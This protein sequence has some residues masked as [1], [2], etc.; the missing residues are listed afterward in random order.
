LGHFPNYV[1]I[2]FS[3]IPRLS[4]PV[5]RTLLEPIPPARRSPPRPGAGWGRGAALNARERGLIAVFALE[6]AA[7]EILYGASNRPDWID[8]P[9]NG[10]AALA[11]QPM[12]AA[13]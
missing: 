10:F 1:L 6:N 7:Y 5:K 3:L 13:L 11:A 8:V 4:L 2:L 12:G 9:L